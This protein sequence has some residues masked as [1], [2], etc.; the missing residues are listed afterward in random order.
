MHTT[1]R[2]TQGQAQGNGTLL[3]FVDSAK[4]TEHVFLNEEI[5]SALDHLRMPYQVLDLAKAPFPSDLST[6]SGI[7][8]AQEKVCGSLSLSQ[9]RRIGQAVE[10]GAGLINLDPFIADCPPILK[11]FARSVLSG[12]KETAPA[13]A[14]TVTEQGHYVIG[15]QEAGAVKSLV[16]PVDMGGAVEMGDE[17]QPLLNTQ[18]GDP[19]LIVGRFR[20]GK[21]VQWMLSPK[22]WLNQVFGHANG[23]DDVFWKSIVWAAGKPFVMM[24]M[25]PFV[26]ARVD[27]AVGSHSHFGYIEIFNRHGIIPAIGLFM[28]EVAEEDVA[29]LRRYVEAGRVECGAH[30]FAYDDLVLY[31]YH[32]GPY[33][34]E[35]V[36]RN[37]RKVDE[38]FRRWGIV[39]ARTVNAHYCEWGSNSLAGLSARG[40]TFAMGWRLPDELALGLHRDWKPAPYGHLGYVFD[41]LPDCPEM[42]VVLSTPGGR[43]ENRVYLPDGAH[44]V[45]TRGAYKEDVDV[46][47]RH[48]TFR[49]ESPVNDIEGAAHAAARQIRLGLDNRFFGCFTTHEQR[50]S[51]LSLEQFDALLTRVDELTAGYDK[52]YRG[53]DDIARYALNRSRVHIARF[54]CDPKSGEGTVRL[55]GVSEVPLQLYVFTEDG[56]EI[57][58]A[59]VDVPPFEGRC[60]V[61]G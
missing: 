18:E 34:Q 49:N 3:V 24:A 16:K 52:I 27:D 12:S 22:L 4:S 40:Q 60:E 1:L 35:Q 47:W 26:T 17:A 10:Q 43:F 31:D 57:R 45:L 61:R 28:D 5:F 14:L 19:A 48:T 7:L 39:P 13:A 20:D 51:A 11:M 56:A 8:V 50:L 59:F 54:D 42:Y 41:A 9:V 33:T 15:T 58:E 36:D 21:I 29:A 55:E 2:F 6:H 38:Q 32:K 30:A 37:L 46:L 23:L 44:F 25:P 53:Y